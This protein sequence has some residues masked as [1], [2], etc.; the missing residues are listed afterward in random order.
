[1]NAPAVGSKPQEVFWKEVGTWRVPSGRLYVGDAWRIFID[2]EVQP[3]TLSVT[4]GVYEIDAKW[5]SYGSDQRVAVLRGRLQGAQ[6]N[7]SRG[8]GEFF[9][10]AASA[11][12]IDGSALDRWT[13][14]DPRAYDRWQK[15]FR[16]AVHRE[17]GFHPCPAIGG[18]ML[19]TSTGFGD[20]SYKA[21]TL[22]EGPTPVGF[23]LRFLEDD[24]GYME[25]SAQ[26]RAERA[27][28][29][30]FMEKLGYVAALP[31]AFVAMVFGLTIGLAARA[32]TKVSHLISRP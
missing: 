13:G 12:V 26:V 19:Y 25:D 29:K 31:V 3:L 28:P 21:V 32:V 20:G 27:R 9:V 24:R 30:T 14:A 15:E 22:F 16:E 18:T 1:V 7:R 23:E 10:D 2:D 6:P 11:G 5:L 8:A 17:I 4:A